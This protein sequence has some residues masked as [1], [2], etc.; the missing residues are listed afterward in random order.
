MNMNKWDPDSDR[1]P[2]AQERRR[3]RYWKPYRRRNPLGRTMTTILWCVLAALLAWEVGTWLG[4]LL[5]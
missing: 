5:R 3:L 2:W 1:E 4:R